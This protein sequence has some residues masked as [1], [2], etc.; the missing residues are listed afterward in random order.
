MLLMVA[1]YFWPG[2]ICDPILANGTLV[3]IRDGFTVTLKDFTLY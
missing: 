2:H 3:E 1:Q